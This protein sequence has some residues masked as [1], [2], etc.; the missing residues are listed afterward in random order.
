MG[1]P[2]AMD[3][4]QNCSGYISN[5]LRLLCFAQLSFCSL[6]CWLNDKTVIDSGDLD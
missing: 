2:I 5:L 4:F 6:G 3:A 1:V